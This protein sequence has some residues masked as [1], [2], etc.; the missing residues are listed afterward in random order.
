MPNRYRLYHRLNRAGGTYYA[1]DCTTGVRVSLG[2]KDKAEAKKLLQAK[3]DAYAQ[4]IL[5]RELAKV[6][7]QAQDPRFGERTWEEV[8]RTRHLEPV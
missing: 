8:E 3:N 1:Q 7:I 5:S 6:Y 4:P 2:T